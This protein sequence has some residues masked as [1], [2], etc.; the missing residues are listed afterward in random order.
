[1]E[2]ARAVPTSVHESPADLVASLERLAQRVLEEQ[3]VDLTPAGMG[4]L[5]ESDGRPTS[6]SV[7]DRCYT[8]QA[9]LDEEQ[10]ITD[11]A[12]DRWSRPGTPAR[13]LGCDQLDPAQARA[14]SQA[15]GTD[16]LVAIVGP[17]GAGKT[18]M[19]RS[20]V[21]TLGATG[22]C[23][24]GLAPS[25]AAAEVLADEAGVDADTVDKLLV[26]YTKPGQLPD[27]RFLLPADTTVIVDSCR[28]RDCA[29]LGWRPPG[30][31]VFSLGCGRGWCCVRSA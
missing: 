9:I 3:C 5:R 6:E 20:A 19:L 23:A 17:A 15:A 2:L 7:L 21:E 26:E 25:A 28:P 24:F 8:T 30:A 27:P 11:W 31:V 1:V 29:D 18:T 12:D 13:L 16:A 22:R 10:S 4:P 14:A